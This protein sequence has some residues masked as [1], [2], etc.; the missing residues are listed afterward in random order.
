MSSLQAI[1]E[2]TCILVRIL[3]LYEHSNKI[4]SIFSKDDDDEKDGDDPEKKKMLEKL[5]GKK[6]FLFSY[7][8]NIL[9]LKYKLIR[10]ETQ[11]F[12]LD[13]VLVV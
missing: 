10:R 4:N 7:K 13:M 1:V 11:P 9:I 3:V 2:V 8:N 5:S 12:I 6:I